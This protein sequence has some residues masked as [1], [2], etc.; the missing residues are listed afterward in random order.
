MQ[1]Y[2]H[3]THMAP[4]SP[5]PLSTFTT[6]H[7][8]HHCVL[9]PESLTAKV[10]VVF[11]ASACPSCQ[12]SLTD[13]LLSGPKLQRDLETTLLNFRLYLFVLTVN[14]KMVCR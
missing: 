3:L 14:I 1:E 5:P 6:Y 8:P 12:T 7:I 9:E 13:H 2:L 4:V 10:R 11:N